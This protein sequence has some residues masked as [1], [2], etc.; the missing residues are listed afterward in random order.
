MPNRSRSA[1]AEFGKPCCAPGG[2]HPQHAQMLDA[3][4]PMPGH[5]RVLAMGDRGP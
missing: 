2:R 3:W 5:S 4:K 1:G